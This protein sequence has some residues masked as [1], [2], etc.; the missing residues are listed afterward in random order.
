M[1][2]A[3]EQQLALTASTATADL[4]TTIL[5]RFPQAQIQPRSALLADEDISLEVGLPLTMP[6]TYQARDWSY[7]TGIELQDRYNLSIF[8]SAVPLEGE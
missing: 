1:T 3:A 7:N 2:Q 4:V 5:A 6:E 8:V